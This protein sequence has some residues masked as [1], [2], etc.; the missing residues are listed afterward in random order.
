MNEM[1]RW[2]NIC[3]SLL[4]KPIRKYE[5]RPMGLN[6]DLNN[7]KN[8]KKLSWDAKEDIKAKI[9]KNHENYF[10]EK[11]AIE[12]H[13]RDLFLQLNECLEDQDYRTEEE[14]HNILIKMSEI[15]RH[16]LSN[17]NPYP[18]LK[19][20]FDS[21]KLFVDASLIDWRN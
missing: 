17:S 18:A 4:A 19:I 20:N 9:H 16:I 6:E 7:L 8:N 3:E 11:L 14:K 2:L 13:N 5:L 10:N 1:T 21:Y 12:L 15:K